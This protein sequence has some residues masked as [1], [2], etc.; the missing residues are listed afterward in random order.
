MGQRQAQ[1]LGGLAYTATADLSAK[2]YYAVIIDASNDGQVVIGTSNCRMLGVLQNKP[3]AGEIAQVQSARGTSSKVVLS[4]TVAAGDD[5]QVD[6][7]G[8][9]IKAASTAQKVVGTF[10]Q[11]GVSGDIVEMVLLDG[12]VA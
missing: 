10:A 8:T 1:G 4:G 12:Y 9:F 6:T 3:K 11:A 2:Q 5:A 7:G